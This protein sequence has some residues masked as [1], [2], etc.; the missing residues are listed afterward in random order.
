MTYQ[1]IYTLIGG[2]FL[3]LG[4]FI[5]LAQPAFRKLLKMISDQ[6][7]FV[8]PGILELAISL[9]LLYFRYETKIPFIITMT[10]ILMFIDGVLYL[11]GPRAVK[12]SIQMLLDMESK[13]LRY[14]SLIFF[15]L[16]AIIFAGGFL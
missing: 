15:L 10:G 3:I 6:E 11:I 9:T 13:Y 12:E 8:M 14:Y 5:N 1:F 2:I 16:A 4:L 7:F